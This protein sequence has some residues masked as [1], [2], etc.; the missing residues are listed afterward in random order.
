MRVWWTVCISALAWGGSAATAETHRVPADYPTINQALDACAYG[1]TV[2]VAPGEYRDAEVRAYWTGWQWAYILSCAH[3]VPGVVLRSE[4]GAGATT[5][6]LPDQDFLISRT[7]TA[8]FFPSGATALIEGFEL[9][10]GRFGQKGIGIGPGHPVVEIRDCVLRGFDVTGVGTGA[11]IDVYEASVKVENCVIEDCHARSGGAIEMRV[12]YDD[13]EISNVSVTDCTGSINLSGGLA[14]YP[15]TVRVRGVRSVRNQG[16]PA[17]YTN[18]FSSAT[19]EDCWFMDGEGPAVWVAG[20]IR[21]QHTVRRC[22][23]M[24]NRAME[25]GG[26]AALVWFNVPGDLEENTFVNNDAFDDRGQAVAFKVDPG[27][28]LRVRRNV[29]AG[30]KSG[31]ALAIVTRSSELPLSAHNIFWANEIGDVDDYVLAE[32]DRVVD[33]EFCGAGR[34]GV[35]VR[36]TSPCL[37]GN[38]ETGHP[39]GAAGLGCTST[40]SV[41]VRSWSKI[42]ALYRGDR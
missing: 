13:I 33:P 41:E 27:N 4:S 28:V 3:L 2:L 20:Q 25:L 12:A 38:N 23:F 17:L 32:T 16:G 21:G 19:I 35:R 30:T 11:G 9:V 10:S 34:V 6:R 8:S 1:D 29:F 15:S 14:G 31:P 37:P 36:S 26:T 42:K 18:N 39:I 5:L 7:I 22:V 40:L 24:G